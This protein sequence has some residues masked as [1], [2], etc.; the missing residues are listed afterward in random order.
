MTIPITAPTST[1]T[2]IERVQ[3]VTFQVGDEL[4][5]ADIFSV[6][7]VLRYAVPRAI[8][9]VPS[10][11]AGVLDYS[12]RAV[13]IIDLRARFE[14]PPAADRAHARILVFRAGEEWIGA[15]VDAVHAVSA[16]DAALIEPPPPVFKG[17][18]KE[19][20]RGLVRREEAL[21]VVLD[22]GRLL[23]A[24]ERVQLLQAISAETSR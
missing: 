4:F 10:W 24:T 15:V 16:I 14:L 12:G 3:L 23:T 9:N 2:P 17:L 18:A 22:A 1:S 19:Y 7:R 13:P 21:W 20:L 6:E 8:P 5:A 11:L